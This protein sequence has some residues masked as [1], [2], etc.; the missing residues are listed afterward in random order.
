MDT[1]LAYRTC[2]EVTRARAGNFYYGIRLL[3]VPKRRALC[4]VYA[5]ARRVDDIG[6]GRLSGEEKLVRLEGARGSLQRID[7]AA[8]DP[9]LSALGHAAHR[10]AIPI[11]SFADLIDGVEMD[12][13]GTTYARF[14]DLLPYCR[15][16]AGSIGRLSV[17]VFE[18]SHPARAAE[19]ADDLGVAMQ[20]T[21]ILRDV[22]EDR[23]AGR[24]Y[25]PAED[26]DRFGC[27]PDPSVAPSAALTT[28]VRFEAARAREWFGRG[29]QLLPLLD[30]RS[31]ACVGAMSGIYRR[32]LARIER[33]P[34]RAVRER[35]SIS[36][37]EKAWV[38]ARSLAGVGA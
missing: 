4:A 32:V 38:A 14:E 30:G 27:G 26:L 11:P 22:R 37:W 34:V 15:R 16:V 12:V 36:S 24:L 6:D 29:L 13:R 19:L 25:L 18:A 31:R 1:E 21:N 23:G 33:E 3:P 9:V 28:L 8:P 5:F 10:F 17:A 35:V 2:E 7:A 20:L